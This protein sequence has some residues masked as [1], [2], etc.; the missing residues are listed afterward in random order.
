AALLPAQ[1]IWEKARRLSGEEVRA[2]EQLLLERPD[3]EQRD[4]LLAYYTAHTRRA[5]RL[6]HCLWLVEHRPASTLHN[7]YYAKISAE[8]SPLNSM[9][10]FQA[11]RSL[12]L[13]HVELRANEPRVLY[14]AAPFVAQFDPNLAERLVLQGRELEPKNRKWDETLAYLYGK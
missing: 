11:A 9:E 14:N 7:P 2:I 8:D 10:A 12:W 6:R 3:D 13:Q 1:D 5:D 4:L